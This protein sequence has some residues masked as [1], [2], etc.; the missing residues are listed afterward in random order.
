MKHAIENAKQ[1]KVIKRLKKKFSMVSFLTRADE[2]ALILVPKE[3]DYSLNSNYFHTLKC[4]IR[5]IKEAYNIKDSIYIV[6]REDELPYYFSG[7]FGIAAKDMKFI[8]GKDYFDAKIS[9][10]SMRDITDDI[11]TIQRWLWRNLIEIGSFTTL[12]ETIKLYKTYIPLIL[13]ILP[14][15]FETDLVEKQI[16]NIGSLFSVL[17]DLEPGRDDSLI[18]F[19]L[20]EIAFRL[21]KVCDHLAR[22]NWSL[23]EED[24]RKI[25]QYANLE[26]RSK[27][28]SLNDNLQKAIDSIVEKLS[29][30]DNFIKF[31]CVVGSLSRGDFVEKLS[32]ID[33]LIVLQDIV[34]DSIDK[35]KKTVRILRNINKILYRMGNYTRQTHGVLVNFTDEIIMSKYSTK[36]RAK[37][38]FAKDHIMLLPF[39]LVDRRGN[40]RR[41]VRE[42]TETRS[43]VI[44]FL[45]DN[46]KKDIVS[47]LIDKLLIISKIALAS[48]GDFGAYLRNK[49][50][51]LAKIIKDYDLHINPNSIIKAKKSENSEK[52]IP[53]LHICEKI[54]DIF[55]RR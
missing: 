21:I 33:L 12:E 48:E 8:F 9:K 10:V 26:E 20:E 44:Q 5:I 47:F 27:Q 54:V 3:Q 42:I 24:W 51:N 13:R 37:F 17:K 32:D 39:Y 6:V 11:Y 43:A 4:L 1:R 35:F 40:K 49:N 28:Y 30:L 22:A 41:M 55:L 52:M 19:L 38:F 46:Y 31:S 25:I 34:K 45:E 2:L 7:V 18:L 36:V 50:L 15:F 23:P 53:I 14:R 16:R 29:E